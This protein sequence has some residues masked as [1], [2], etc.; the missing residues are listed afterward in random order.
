[1]TLTE[2]YE[3]YPAAVARRVSRLRAAGVDGPYA[4]ALGP[5]CYT[6]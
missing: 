5:R 4:I 3:A 1:V 2:D 6:G